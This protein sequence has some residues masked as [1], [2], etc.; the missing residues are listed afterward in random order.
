[1]ALAAA[2]FG[3]GCASDPSPTTDH[4]LSGFVTN[5]TTTDPVSG[6]SVTFSSDTLY[7]TSATTDSDGYYEMVIQTDSNFG[8]VRAEKA[9]Y[10]VNE[11]TVYFDSDARRVDF[12]LRP[13]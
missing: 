9:G 10:F 4:E 11:M 5:E 7:T 3:V 6:A 2:S 13:E 12:T 8:Q 1:M